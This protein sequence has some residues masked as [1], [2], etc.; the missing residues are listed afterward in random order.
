MG[1]DAKFVRPGSQYTEKREKMPCVCVDAFQGRPTPR[2][3]V[4]L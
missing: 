1:W 2:Q 4:G 3:T